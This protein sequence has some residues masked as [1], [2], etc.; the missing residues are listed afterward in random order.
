MFGKWFFRLRLRRLDR[1]FADS[2]PGLQRAWFESAAASGRPRG[3][4]W[5]GSRWLPQRVLL[6]EKQTGELWMLN[7]VNLQF[8]AIPGGGM[9]DVAAVSQ[10]KEGSAVFVWSGTSWTP[11]GRTLFNLDPAAAA[12]HLEETHELCLL[13]AGQ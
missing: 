2:Q 9:E 5:Q 8:S 3:L 13:T 11:N 10:L 4:E 6:R 12:R 1:I 7:G